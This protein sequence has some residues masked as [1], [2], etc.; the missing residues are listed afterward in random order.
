MSNNRK[1]TSVGSGNTWH[2]IYKLLESLGMSVVGA[3][4][5]A[6]GVGG[7]M[8]GG[9]I[10][11]FSGHYGWVCDNVLSYEVILADGSIVEA[12]SS[13]NS[14][15]Y[16]ARRGGSGTNFGIVSRFDLATFEQRSMWG[17]TG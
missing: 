14:D 12:S 8:L 3:R 4:D 9:G 15:I 1:V 2:N 16:W 17:G 7:L 6:V 11:Y 10:S 13:S 5:A